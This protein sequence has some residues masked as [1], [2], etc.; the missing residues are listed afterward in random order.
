VAARQRRRTSWR[1][2]GC[3][4]SMGCTGGN[5]ARASIEPNE[6]RGAAQPLAAAWGTYAAA[7][8]FFQTV[9]RPMVPPYVAGQCVD[10]LIAYGFL[11]STSDES[12]IK[13]TEMCI[14]PA[15]A[16]Q[17]RSRGCL[18]W[19][20]LAGARRL[21]VAPP[22]RLDACVWRAGGAGKLAAAAL[23]QPARPAAKGSRR[24]QRAGRPAALMMQP[25]L[26]RG[27]AP[28][29]HAQVRLGG[30]PAAAPPADDAGS[31]RAGGPPDS[32][33][34]GGAVLLLLRC[35]AGEARGTAPL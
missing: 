32:I 19:R 22:R 23:V 17:P 13:G 6:Q 33:R 3:P 1:G 15:P 29:P 31:R 24:R 18:G 27:R 8:R 30:R 28:L 35:C 26:P 16:V 14:P 12:H 11:A 34:R 5:A 20:A 25:R 9:A 7:P 10:A 21:V 4:G 2:A